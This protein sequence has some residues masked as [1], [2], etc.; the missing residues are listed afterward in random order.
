MGRLDEALAA[1]DRTVKR[2]PDDVVARNAR[3]VILMELGHYD[4]AR[5]ALPPGHVDPH[6]RD[7]WIAAHIMCRI[8]LRTRNDS[9]LVQRV[10]TLVARCPFIEQ[11]RYFATLL[12]VVRLARSQVT[13]AR[14]DIRKILADPGLTAEDRTVVYLMGAHAAAAEGR[15]RVRLAARLRRR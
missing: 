15:Y 7:E 1:Y 2:F 4:D 5:A 9:G 13:E 8:E 3:A 11:R 10:E 12:P 14:A 6:T